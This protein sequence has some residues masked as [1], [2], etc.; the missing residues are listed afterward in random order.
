MKRTDRSFSSALL[1]LIA[2]AANVYE[3]QRIDNPNGFMYPFSWVCAGVCAIGFIMFLV[4]GISA[5]LSGD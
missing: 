5:H 3:A 1:C 4:M 2:A